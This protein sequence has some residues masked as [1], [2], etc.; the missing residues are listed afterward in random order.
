[1]TQQE[2]LD[3]VAELFEEDSRQLT[4]DTIRDDIEAWDSLG[5]LTLLAALDRDFGIILSD[6]EVQ[7]M[8]Q[9]DDI[10][11]VLRRNGKLS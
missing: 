11:D 8:R 2:V 6:D 5:V 4:P 3:W 7:G 10:L 9:V 1:V